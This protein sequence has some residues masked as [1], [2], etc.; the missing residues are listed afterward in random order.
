[1]YFI[2]FLKKLLNEGQKL[3]L[4]ESGAQRVYSIHIDKTVIFNMADLWKRSVTVSAPWLLTMAH[5]FR[6]CMSYGILKQC[7]L[8]QDCGHIT[9]L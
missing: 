4:R 1:M 9:D 7:A 6:Q 8:C 2:G 3:I 5:N